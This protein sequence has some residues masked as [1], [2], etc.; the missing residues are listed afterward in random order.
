MKITIATQ[1][2]NA[3]NYI[4]KCIKSVLQQTYLNF[5]YIL[6]DNGCN[7]GSE[8]IMQKYAEED[9][10]IKLVRYE[11]NEISA[12]WY[13]A[14]AKMGTGDYFTMLDADDWL[15]L[16]YLERLVG[17]AESTGA[18]IISTGSHMHVEGTQQVFD[19]SIEQRL[20]LESK[21]FANAFPCYHVFFRPIWAKLIRTDLLMTTPVLL[22]QDTG[23]AYGADTLNSFAWLRHATRICIDNSVLHH[24]R[25][26]QK[27]V[28]HKYD[29][30][31]SFSDLYLF[32][33]AIDFLS[34]YGPISA[35]NLGFLYNVYSYAVLDTNANIKKST[36]SPAEK[37]HEYRVI[38]ERDVTKNAYS[39]GSEP[40]QLSRA[41]LM[42]SVLN[43]AAELS[44]DNEDLNAIKELYFP[45]CGAAVYSDSAKL[46]LTDNALFNSLVNDDRKSIVKYI[47]SLIEKQKLV[48]QFE[49]GE[50]LRKLS[51]DNPVLSEISDVKFLKKYGE[52]YLLAW[53]KNYSDVLDAMT[54]IL[55]KEAVSSSTFLNLYLTI[56]AGL[57]C[58]DE[59][60]FGK[61][62]LAAYYCAQKRADDCRAI[63]NDLTEMGVEDNDEILE[64]K[65][66][67]KLL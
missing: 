49:L 3:K 60:V 24:Y 53:S 39:S 47:L 67:L 7:D 13:V 21:D 2:Y 16:D 66:Q 41:D 48:K 40:A 12:R 8:V 27:S 19:R 33:D 38:L 45:E 15:E 5:E 18:D 30:R 51:Q 57:E 9:S 61:V 1:A 58:A 65:R 35:Q 56:A 26:H 20:V 52:I 43:C 17:L 28:S 46:F 36:L 54:D 10:K 31:Q 22:S 32:K 42:S 14:L 11:E 6:V 64:I 29:P 63:L 50:I 34:P 55:L 59:F 44:D 25:I 4:E 23:V 37:M 62:K